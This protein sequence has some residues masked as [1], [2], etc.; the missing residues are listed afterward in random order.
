MISPPKSSQKY[1]LLP[2]DEWNF[3]RIKDDHL[4]ACLYYECARTSEIIPKVVKF[5][6][7]HIPDFKNFPFR[8]SFVK[9]REFLDGLK[10]TLRE[11]FLLDCL[12]D[13]DFRIAIISEAFP[14]QPW[15]RLAPTEIETAPKL[16]NWNGDSPLVPTLPR[17]LSKVVF[18]GNTFTVDWAYSDD[19]LKKNFIKWLKINRRFPPDKFK[20]GRAER[21]EDLLHQ[22]GTLR[23]SCFAQKAGGNKSMIYLVSK[24]PRQMDERNI[25]RA[26]KKISN[27]IQMKERPIARLAQ[28]TDAEFERGYPFFVAS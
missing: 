15:Q 6:R 13:S 21:P 4:K 1:P 22:L 17:N 23:L 16:L 14:V 28:L 3:S 8:G 27:F 9:K 18:E 11:R 26:C 20:P 5:W 19:Y 2:Q 10:I 12:A 25:N 24:P 7:E